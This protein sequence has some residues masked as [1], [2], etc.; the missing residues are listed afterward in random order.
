MR[1]RPLADHFLH[2]A[3]DISDDKAFAN[4]GYPAPRALTGENPD[5]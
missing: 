1:S 3:H 2:G 5:A 4:I